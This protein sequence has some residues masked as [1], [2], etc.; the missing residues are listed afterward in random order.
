VLV[1]LASLPGL[2]LRLHHYII[3]LMLLPSTAFPTRLSAIYQA[4]L[5][6]L[7]INGG[8]AF[9]WDSILQTADEVRDRT[10]HSHCT[11]G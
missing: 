9:E 5:L 6:G 10:G 11:V 7:F 4:F 1:V 8:A 2:T 3:A